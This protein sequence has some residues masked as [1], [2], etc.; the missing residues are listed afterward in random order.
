MEENLFAGD[1]LE[2]DELF[3]AVAE[4]FD[5]DRL[6]FAGAEGAFPVGNGGDGVRADLEDDVAGFEAG[7]EGGAF[8]GDALDD[9]A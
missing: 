8:A 1:D 6:A 4:D 5:L 2:E 9:E 3:G 7:D